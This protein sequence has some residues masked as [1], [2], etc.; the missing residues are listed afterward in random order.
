MCCK[1]NVPVFGA[2]KCKGLIQVDST[3]HLLFIILP[4]SSLPSRKTEANMPAISAPQISG[5]LPAPSKPTPT[6]S[7]D[8]VTTVF[9]LGGPAVQAFSIGD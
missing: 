6:F 9:V 3:L 5:G 8:D 1:A 4:F 7:P 2:Q